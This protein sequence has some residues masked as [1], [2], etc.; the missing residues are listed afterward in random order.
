[1]FLYFRE[2]D[3]LSE[4]SDAVKN[5]LSMFKFWEEDIS[6]IIVFNFTPS[7]RW[8]LFGILDHHAPVSLNV[9]LALV[10]S[11]VHHDL[12]PFIKIIIK[13]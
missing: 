8:N 13:Q 5:L 4:A 6:F 10:Y 3:G 12:S 7:R 2:T 9:S 1:M 11:I